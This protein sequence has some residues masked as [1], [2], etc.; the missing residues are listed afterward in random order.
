MKIAI[1]ARALGIGKRTGVEEYELAL[2]SALFKIDKENEYILFNNGFFQKNN[3]FEQFGDNPNVKIVNLRIPNK[4]FN[5]AITFLN[6]PKLDKLCGSPDVFFSP[7]WNFCK[8]SK[9]I[10]KIITVHDLSFEISPDFFSL[11]K[12][13]WHKIVAVKK[14]ALEADKIIAVSNASKQ[15]L[16]NIYGIASEKIEVIYPGINNSF[17]KDCDVKEKQEVRNKYHLPENFILFIGTIEPRKGIQN[18]IQSFN[19]FKKKDVSNIDLVIS[20]VRGWSYRE[21]LKTA[22]KS[23][24]AK[25]IHF[26]GFVHDKDKPAFIQSSKIFIYPSFYEG[27]GFPPLEAMACKIPVIISHNPSLPEISGDGALMI[28]PWNL[29]E[30]SWSIREVIADNL[31]RHA[32]IKKGTECAQ[33]YKWENAAQKTLE[34]IKSIYL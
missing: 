14:Q 28:N 29:D 2:L 30:F 25:N 1:D 27:F 34:A 5:S 33:K 23:P 26:T 16:L 24:Y 21:I 12:R 20:G 19:E 6:Y 11:K 13:L 8:L 32:L 31:L 7:S 22:A 9:G 4:I 3:E 10:R 15:D 17:F 18:L